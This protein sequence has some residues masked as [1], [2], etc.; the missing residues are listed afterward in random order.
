MAA[1]LEALFGYPAW[2]FAL[3]G[4]PVV[5]MGRLI[6]TL[7]RHFNHDDD[8]PVRRRIAGIASLI[9]LLVATGVSAQVLTFAIFSLFGPNVIGLLMAALCAS[10]CL[11]QRSLAKHVADVAHALLHVFLQT[12][13]QEDMQGG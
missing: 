2:L 13:T 6:A 7:D 9:I 1:G 4:H 10:S 8:P 11:A 5:W 3:I 12:A